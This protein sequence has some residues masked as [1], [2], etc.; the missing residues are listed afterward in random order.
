[1]RKVWFRA[2]CDQLQLRAKP[3]ESSGQQLGADFGGVPHECGTGRGGEEE[4]RKK[5]RRG[6]RGGTLGTVDVLTKVS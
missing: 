1:L 3:R 6:C 5:K 2:R 4:Q